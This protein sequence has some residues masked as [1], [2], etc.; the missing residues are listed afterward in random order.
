MQ[1]LLMMNVELFNFKVNVNAQTVQFGAGVEELC[2]VAAEPTDGLYQY[3]V[4]LPVAAVHHHLL[5]VFHFSVVSA[6]RFVGIHA[7]KDPV[8]FLRD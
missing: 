2:S 6:G 8:R 5:K 4:Y 7:D 3:Q 1:L